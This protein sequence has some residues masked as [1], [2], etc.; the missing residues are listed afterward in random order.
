MRS[1]SFVKLLE[2]SAILPILAICLACFYK[3][4]FYNALNLP[5][6][7]SQLQISGILLNAIPLFL[8]MFIGF[9]MATTFYLSLRYVWDGFQLYLILI[10]LLIFM[11][12]STVF[13]NWNTNTLEAILDKSFL[14]YV[15]FFV[16]TVLL[17]LDSVGLSRSIL[18]GISIASL[19]LL[20]SF[21]DYRS[22]KEVKKLFYQH[23]SFSRVYFTEEGQKIVPI[24]YTSE[25]KDGN[26][27]SY[28]LDWRLL[29]LVGDKAIIIVSNRIEL[30]NIKKPQVRIVE[31]KLIDRVY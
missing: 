5:W 18:I 25:D 4:S 11:M 17:A 26:R 3:Y 1:I 8:D 27:Q 2:F 24:S 29:E 10:L 14:Y 22:Y 15:F 7:T 6:I 31:Y 28:E 20:Q 16:V 12:V 13:L 30:D 19:M 21:I 23:D 9:V